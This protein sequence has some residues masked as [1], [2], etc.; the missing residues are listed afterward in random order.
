MRE[1]A[2]RNQNQID[3]VK[4]EEGAWCVVERDVVK[5][6]GVLKIPT[7]SCSPILKLQTCNTELRGGGAVLSPSAQASS[8]AAHTMLLAG[9]GRRHLGLPRARQG[10]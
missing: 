5:E 7:R 8:S 4:M 9:G 10:G 3:G 2:A 1:K 6:R